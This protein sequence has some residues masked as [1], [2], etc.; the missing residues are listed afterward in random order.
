MA[1]MP[2]PAECGACCHRQF[3]DRLIG[4]LC[5][6]LTA[7]QDGQAELEHEKMFLV[8]QVVDSHLTRLDD[9]TFMG[10]AALVLLG[11]RLKPHDVWGGLLMH[12]SW[13]HD[14]FQVKSVTPVEHM[15]HLVKALL[16]GEV[17]LRQAE[18]FSYTNRLS[19]EMPGTVRA[20]AKKVF[21]RIQHT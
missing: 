6:D 10:V 19:P 13:S 21:G 15:R 3:V 16:C 11:T 14:E 12:V 2:V 4:E 1:T 17:W 18:L 7:K 5:N 20:F 9:Q 8:E